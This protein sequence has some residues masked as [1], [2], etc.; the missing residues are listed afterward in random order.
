M[1]QWELEANTRNQRQAG[2]GIASDWLRRWRDFFK[3]I[4]TRSQAKPKQ[5]SDYFRH[6]IENRSN[7]VCIYT[8]KASRI[9]ADLENFFSSCLFSIELREAF[10]LFDKDGGGSISSSELAAVMRSLGQNPTEDELKEMIADVDEDGLFDLT[11]FFEFINWFKANN[12][13]VGKLLTKRGTLH[14]LCGMAITLNMRTAIS[15]GQWQP[16]TAV[17]A[18]LG[19]KL[20]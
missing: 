19:L 17:S 11:I 18:L 14:W 5:I 2:F 9:R 8:N 3:P 12:W 20:A 7:I 6:S 1:N 15:P 13:V 16:W 10:S 4:I